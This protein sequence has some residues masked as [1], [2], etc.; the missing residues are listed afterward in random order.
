MKINLLKKA[1]GDDQGFT[2]IETLVATAVLLIGILSLYSMQVTSVKFNATASGITTSTNW[3]ADR[4]EQ[5]LQLDY[6]DANLLDGNGNGLAGLNDVGNAADGTIASPDGN[7]VISWNI[8]ELL[9]PNP[10]DPSDSTLKTI[11]VIVE[12]NDF[13]IIRQTVLNYYKQKVF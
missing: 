2:L 5:I 7:Y 8:A 3:A 6:L 1:I 13:G 9:A 11:R 12:R 4:I 10:N